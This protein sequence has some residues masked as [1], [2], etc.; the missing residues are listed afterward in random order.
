M[1]NENS[2][3]TK[4]KKKRTIKKACCIVIRDEDRILLKKILILNQF[5]SMYSQKERFLLKN[6]KFLE[7]F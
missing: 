7:F 4:F 1:F 2:I 3:A 6:M 5:T